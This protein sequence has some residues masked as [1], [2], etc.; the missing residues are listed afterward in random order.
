[1]DKHQTTYNRV[2]DQKRLNFITDVLKEKLHSGGTAL[3]VGCGNGIIS[4]YLGRYG[5]NVTGID[6]SEKAIKY[7]IENNSFPNVKFKVESAEGIVA[8]GEQFDVIICSEVLEH[9]HDPS[10]LVKTLY[11]SLKSDGVLIITVP[12]G[13][14]PRELFVTKPILKLRGKNGKLWALVS[15]MKSKL[16]Y[17]GTT[18]QSTADNLDHVQFFT[19]RD[20]KNMLSNN[21]FKAIKYGKANFI[22]DVFPF[23]IL[24]KRF[25]ILQ[26]IDCKIADW[27]PIIFTGGFFSVWEKKGNL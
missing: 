8:S 23:S 9:L 21:N 16:G 18:V 1:M 17:S 10:S 25:K 26:K 27:L 22:E 11:D 2:A 6:I 20:L 12:N 14:G 19:L 13:Y 24:T 15:S 4:L 7:A 5:F 3:D